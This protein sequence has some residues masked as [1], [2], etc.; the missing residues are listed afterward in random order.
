MVPTVRAVLFLFAIVALSGFASA[1]T[2]NVTKFG[3]QDVA[4]AGYVGLGVVGAS[5]TRAFGKHADAVVGALGM[6]GAYK[7]A[8]DLSVLQ[9]KGPKAAAI[10]AALVGTVLAGRRHRPVDRVGP[11]NARPTDDR[12]ATAPNVEPIDDDVS[13]DSDDSTLAQGPASDQER[14]SYDDIE[15]VTVDD[16]PP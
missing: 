8:T 11:H 2:G 7:L 5:I 9:Q 1:E 15:M 10:L 4:Q 3:V 14:V 13:L 12:P 16:V 6:Y